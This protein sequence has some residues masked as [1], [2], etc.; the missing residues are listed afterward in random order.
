MVKNTIFDKNFSVASTAYNRSQ[1]KYYNI[2]QVIFFGRSNVGKSSLINSLCH[3]KNLAKT[4]KTPGRTESI[5]FFINQK[6]NFILVDIPGYGFAKTN[7]NDRNNWEKLL[8][9]YLEGNNHIL[10]TFILLDIRRGMMKIDYQMIDLLVQYQI[11][12]QIILTKSYKLPTKE[13]DKIIA[14]ITS[15]I[16][17]TPLFFDPIFPISNTKKTGL[18]ELKRYINNIYSN[19]EKTKITK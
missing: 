15:Q 18:E 10:R 4:S 6:K 8:L 9:S 11:P 3:K 16:N 14:D 7:K 5:N 19:S 2:P 1:L 13:I 17:N 12:F